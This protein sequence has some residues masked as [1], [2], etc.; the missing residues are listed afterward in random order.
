[1]E[2]AVDEDPADHVPGIVDAVILEGIV[3]EVEDLDDPAIG[4]KAVLLNIGSPHH[5][6]I[7]GKFE[8][9]RMHHE[10]ENIQSR[11]SVQIQRV[12][13]PGIQTAKDISGSG[14][15]HEKVPASVLADFLKSSKTDTVL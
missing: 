7:A 6:M 14:S 13:G 8:N 9:I 1:M 2:F 3:Q 5:F 15:W 11:I 4:T 12:R 10:D